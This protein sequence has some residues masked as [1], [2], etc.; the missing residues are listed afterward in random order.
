MEN[1]GVLGGRSAYNVY[2]VFVASDHKMLWLESR[3]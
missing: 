3:R 1:E 2:T